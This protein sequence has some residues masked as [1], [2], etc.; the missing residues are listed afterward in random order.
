[1]F[2]KVSEAY[3]VLSDPTR[4][5]M[6]DQYGLEAVGAGQ[7]DDG[8]ECA[9]TLFRVSHLQHYVHESLIYVIQ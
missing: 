9:D 7:A 6:Y 5:M 1:M 4:R 8:M 3:E 2:R